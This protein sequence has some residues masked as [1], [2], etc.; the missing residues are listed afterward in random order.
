M[1]YKKAFHRHR[2][3][4]TVKAMCSQ[5]DMNTALEGSTTCHPKMSLW[6]AN[7]FKLK[8]IQTQKTQGETLSSPDCLKSL[9]RG[10]VPPVQI[11][12]EKSAKNM[13]EM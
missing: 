7:Y 10:S 3:I 1:N 4:K 13:G 6:Y 9:D 11:S 2:C 5:E 12:P 8:T